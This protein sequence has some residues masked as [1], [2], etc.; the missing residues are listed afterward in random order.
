MKIILIK[1]YIYNFSTN[2][3]I[4]KR[5]QSCVLEAVSLS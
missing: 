2:I 4:E 1:V 5:S 3:Y